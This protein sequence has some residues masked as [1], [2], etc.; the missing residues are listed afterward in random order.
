MIKFRRIELIEYVSIL[1]PGEPSAVAQWTKFGSPAVIA[2]G[3][4]LTFSPAE[5]RHNGD[6]VCTPNNV[7]GDG[8]ADI[9]TFNVNGE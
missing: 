6:Y 9:K 5:L 7:V 3:E 8:E 2:A 1:L 4:S